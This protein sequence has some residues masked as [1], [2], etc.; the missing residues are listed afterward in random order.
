[1]P[2]ISGNAKL[3]GVIGWP[4]G[5]SRSPRLHNAWLDRYGIDG[6]YL[7]LP[8][9][10]ADFAAAVRGLAAAGFAGAN[11]TVPHKE[12]A[13]ALCD[14]HDEAA[15]MSGSVNTLVFQDGAIEGRSTDGWGFLES[16]RA[17]HVN[18]VAGPVLLLGAG[19]AARAIA[20]ALTAQG[21]QVTLTNRT[22][23]RAESLARS[24]HCSTLPWQH[25]A[26]SLGDYALLVNTTS[27][28][29]HGQPP[30]ALPLAKA[31]PTLAV[32]DI[33]YVPLQ[34][35]LIVDAAARG[36]ATVGGLGMLLHQ[37]R[38]GFAAWFGVIPGVDRAI[39]DLI[40]AD[41]PPR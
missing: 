20:A 34:T 31:A 13:F 37:A 39:H 4:V 5:H 26:G 16:L 40:A 24:L 3:A 23:E 1:M 9:R 41:I 33:V 36:L 6:A 14:T 38:A 22:P 35:K 30:L 2:N 10:P 8:V 29:M 12:A 32:A 28:G 11:V 27:L 17:E 7:P 18:P 25:A 15:L 19:G 21:A